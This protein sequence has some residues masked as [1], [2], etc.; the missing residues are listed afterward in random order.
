MRIAIVNPP[1]RDPADPRRWITVPPQGYGG[2]QWVCAH[3]IN[4]LLELGHDVTLLGAPGSRLPGAKVLDLATAEEFA[5]W[6][7]AA[8]IDI[9]HDHTNGLV[10]PH[11]VGSSVTFL[12]THHL[13]GPPTFPVNCT[14]LSHAQRGAASGPVIPLPA[15]PKRH[16]F[17]TDKEDY[18]LF[19]GRISAHKGAYEA[20]AFASAAGIRLLMSGPSWE[21]EYLRR[22][23]SD[24]PQT[25]WIGETGGARRRELLAAATAVLVLSQPVPGPWGHLWSEPGATVVSEAAMSGT[26][27]VLTRNG[28]LPELGTGVGQFVDYGCPFSSAYAR[29]VMARIPSPHDVRTVAL[30][31]WHY[32][33]ISRSYENVYR[34]LL[35]GDGWEDP[36]PPAHTLPERPAVDSKRSLLRAAPLL[37]TTPGA[38]GEDPHRQ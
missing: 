14:Y 21:P 30:R 28:C 32:L 8:D 23:L 33:E 9:V 27:V 34:R 13:T 4:G 2:I 31:R 24:F 22:I 17:R 36:T 15:D 7:S 11:D 18:A 29:S 37:D 19:L 16:L 35:A 6:T 26:P 5:A 20:A 3:L 1:Y 38:R 12:S 10:G 25:Q